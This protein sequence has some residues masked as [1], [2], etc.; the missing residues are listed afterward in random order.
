ME[1][2]A[3]AIGAPVCKLAIGSGWTSNSQFDSIGTMTVSNH[4]IAAFRRDGAVPLRGVFADWVEQLRQGIEK[5]IAA[6]SA[7]ARI[8]ESKGEG[9]RFFGDYCNWNRIP[10]FEDFIF[11]SG[12]AAIA[13]KLMGAGTVRLFHE[14]VLVKEPGSDVATPWHQ[15]APYYC[16]RAEKTCS[17]WIPLDPVPRERTLE[18][19]AGSHV[20]GKTYRPERFNRTTLNEG[21]MREAVP[22]IDGNRERFDILG[23]AL[24]PGDAVAFQYTTL[25]GAPANHSR[26]ERRRAFS[27]RVVG[28]DARFHRENGKVFS[29]P[30]ANVALASGSALAGKEFPVL[31]QAGV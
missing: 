12:A 1:R 25:H 8:Y 26:A 11:N 28:D 10:E 5:N 15:D 31:F 20:S 4:E 16:I 19:I 24:Q 3:I 18:F 2:S 7:D 6:P 30:F 17:L 22:D 14:H 27:L 23:W 21:D 13:A 9:G 29:P